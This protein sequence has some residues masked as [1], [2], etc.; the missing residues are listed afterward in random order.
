[1]IQLFRSKLMIDPRR[2][3]FIEGI[4][5]WLAKNWC[6]RFT[7]IERSQYSEVTSSTEWRASLPALFT[8]TSAVLY[9]VNTVCRQFCREPMSVRSHGRNRGSVGPC[10]LIFA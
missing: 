10:A 2:A 4:T 1:M 3:L 9:F 7:A 6:F 5:T 8:N